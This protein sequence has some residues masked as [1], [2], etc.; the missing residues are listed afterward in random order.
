MCT[1]LT[2]LLLVTWSPCPLGPAVHVTSAS[3]SL[4]IKSQPAAAHRQIKHERRIGRAFKRGTPTGTPI[5][6]GERSWTRDGRIASIVTLNATGTGELSEDK[7]SSLARYLNSRTTRSEIAYTY[8]A[9][10]H[11]TEERSSSLGVSYL[12]KCAYDTAT[13]LWQGVHYD[14]GKISGY[15]ITLYDSADSIVSICEFDKTHMLLSA[16]SVTFDGA[17]RRVKETRIEFGKGERV[18]AGDSR[19]YTY[20]DAGRLISVEMESG[21]RTYAT[22]HYSY[23]AANA[24]PAALLDGDRELRYKYDADG[25]MVEESETYAGK[26][27]GYRRFEYDEYGSLVR[28]NSFNAKEQL[29]DQITYELQYW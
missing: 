8:D 5:N 12:T 21:G 22:H 29:V 28:E 15:R 3:S 18:I 17:H 16:D 9:A 14:G 11:V 25:R 19:M 2:F 24:A 13:H 7:V 20:D 23:D 27:M 1:L 4:Q 26:T 10:G 6:L